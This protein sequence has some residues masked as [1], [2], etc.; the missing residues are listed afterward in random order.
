MRRARFAI[1]GALTLAVVLGLAAVAVAAPPNSSER[2][3]AAVTPTGILQHEL[4]F[5][6]IADQNGN[7]RAS[8]TPGYY[9]SR[10]YVARELRQA[11]YTVR[12]Q[13]FEYQRFDEG[14]PAELELTQPEQ[15]SYRGGTDFN[16]MEYSGAGEETAS[17]Q[18]VDVVIPPGPT[19]SSNTSGC[20]DEDFAGFTAGDVALV[21]RGTCTFGVK[22]LNAQ[23]AGA[24]AV[25]IFNEGQPG[26]QEALSG[27][28]GGAG[29]EIPVLGTSFAVGQELYTLDQQGDAEVR[30]FADGSI[31]TTTTSNV[32]AS[33]P[34]GNMSR[35]VVVGSHLDSVPEG[36]GIND[37]GSGSAT[38]LEIARQMARLDVKPNNKVRFAF[39]GAEESGLLGSTY[40]VDQLPEERLNEVMVNL[41]FDMVGSP[42]FVRFVYDGD[43]SDTPLAGPDGSGKV[44]DIFT[45]YFDSQGQASDPTEFSGRS[46]YGPFIEAG[47]PAG[48]LFSGAEGIKT[49]EQA[50]TY[51][52]TPGVAYDPCYHQACDDI[53][54]LSI[55]ALGDF[56]DAAAHATYYFAKTKEPVTDGAAQPTGRAKD[57][58]MT[59]LGP[60][61]QR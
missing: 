60:H 51:G 20:E 39:W 46:D 15:R 30:V 14:E 55:R 22:A 2:L 57:A 4:E 24:S 37:N 28:L 12:I 56:S 5:Q 21:Q 8:G 31:K 61:T 59:Y 36:P 9:G 34:G 16:I 47:I 19:P 10:M 40:Y 7:S 18:P 54:N 52:G 42:N 17:I 26:R 41:N 48:G 38:I 53:D 32:I 3:R 25:L 6:E 50:A 29:F 11:G 35:T 13:P 49:A 43:G 23:E 58:P 44:E 33:L 27:T 1:V 45:D